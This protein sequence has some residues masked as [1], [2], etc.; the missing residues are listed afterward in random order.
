MTFTTYYGPFSVNVHLQ[1][2]QGDTVDST[3]SGT[4]QIQ[5]DPTGHTNGLSYNTGSLTTTVHVKNGGTT[6]QVDPLDGVFD[7]TGLTLQQAIVGDFPFP[8]TTS[9]NYSFSGNTLNITWTETIRNYTDPSAPGLSFNG[10]LNFTATLRAN[11]PPVAVGSS[12][13]IAEDGVAS[14]SMSASDPNG[15]PLTYVLI[16]APQHGYVTFNGPSYTYHPNANYNGTDSFNFQANDGKSNS[17]TATVSITVTPVNDPPTASSTSYAVNEDGSVTGVLPATDPDGDP[18]AFTV[19]AAPTLGT[20][21]LGANGSFTYHPN[22]NAFGHDS[23]SFS[24]SDGTASS[25]GVVQLTIN[26]IDDPPVLAPVA[27][28]EVS[29]GGAVDIK[30]STTLLAGATDVENDPLT[31]TGVTAG[32]H[33]TVQLANDTVTYTANPGYVGSDSFTYTVSDGH[34]GTAVGVVNV[35]VDPIVPVS[36][37]SLSQLQNDLSASLQ[38][39]LLASPYGARF[40]GLDFSDPMVASA[41]AGNPMLAA[42]TTS[43]DA[44]SV[45]AAVTASG[46]SSGLSAPALD[47]YIQ[48][49]L[50]PIL[51]LIDSALQSYGGHLQLGTTTWPPGSDL[52]LLAALATQEP[53]AF[54]D[55]SYH[56]LAIVKAT[57]L[58]SGAGLPILTGLQ[59]EANSKGFLNPWGNGGPDVLLDFTTPLAGALGQESL[60]RPTTGNFQYYITPSADLSFGTHPASPEWYYDVGSGQVSWPVDMGLG[61][62][63]Q[64]FSSMGLDLFGSGTGIYYAGDRFPLHLNDTLSG[65]SGDDGITGGQG[66]DFLTGG[67]RGSDRLDGGPGVDTASFLGATSGMQANLS[68]SGSQNTGGGSVTFIS[69]ENLVGSAFDDR[70]TGD[71]AA[72]AL[73]GAGGNDTLDGGASNDVLDGGPGNDLFVVSPGGGADHI[74]DFMAGG[75]DDSVDLTAY[76]HIGSFEQVLAGAVQVGSDTVLELGD[77]DSVTLNNV[78][79][80]AL[81][82]SDFTLPA[83][84]SPDFGSGADFNGDGLADTL[85]RASN[86]LVALWISQPGTSAVSYVGIDTVS[87]AWHIQGSGDF[88]GDG[89]ADIL[90]R[91]DDGFMALWQSTPSGQYSYVGL[92]QVGLNWH[93]Q[94]AA[95]FN[96]DGKADVLWR[97]D[98]GLTAEWQSNPSNADLTYV[99]VDQVN[100][101]WHVQATADFNGDGLADILWRDDNGLVAEWLSV[102]GT[103]QVS[104]VGLNTVPLDWH[105]LGAGDFNGDGKA[106]ILWRND[107]GLVGLWQSIPGS[108]ELPYVGLANVPLSWHMQ[109]IGDFNNDGKADVLWRDDTGRT[110]LWDST[111][112]GGISYQDLGVVGA[113]WFIS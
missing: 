83:A 50:A 1:D 36:T 94:A 76:A 9:F 101:N 79:R 77:E 27:P 12:I 102:P 28:V 89:K 96:G 78:S 66:D 40:G 18:L 75:A 25:Q 109:A 72:N 111:P 70:L 31:V 55:S 93:V 113:T 41:F 74:T 24:A 65:D 71:G 48:N 3:G 110:A 39:F 73:F 22:P 30:A 43:G 46:F 23:F 58:Y 53:V 97:D 91:R 52:M 84:I 80:N 81:A 82:A 62:F 5:V 57:T 8:G 51:G 32:A 4:I 67:G 103:S 47:G 2:Q 35:T 87:S 33:G 26:S 100:L 69:I 54:I 68:L 56:I 59:I 34:G 13:S 90:W 45:L 104:Y 60:S 29:S 107:S 86:G 92:G 15:D 85:W 108:S 21:T 98:N 44:N 7:A 19:T 37:T 64:V 17:N 99:G 105:I 14:G 88:D 16:N 42:L 95:D 20:V 106:D 61:Q 10:N 6:T 112:G 11:N 63:L 38:A 49:N